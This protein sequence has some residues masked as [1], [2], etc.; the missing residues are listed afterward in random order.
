MNVMRRPI[1]TA[2]LLLLALVPAAAAA[3]RESGE[4]NHETLRNGP[5]KEGA[6]CV[7]AGSVRADK[8]AGMTRDQGDA[9]LKELRQIRQ[10]LEKQQAQLARLLA[11]PPSAPPPPERVQMNVGSGWNALGRADAPVTVVE[12]A[13][14][15]CPFCKRFHSGTFAELKK[16]YIDTG[17]VRWVSRDLPIEIHAHALRAA[18]AARCAGDQGK[19]WEMRD[20][21]LS[22]GS[23]PNDEVIE[24][25]AERLSLD[26]KVFQSCLDS[27][28]HGGEVQKDAMEAATLH[29][30]GT[31][32]F[33][34]ARAA[35]DKLDGVRILGAQALPVFQSAIEPL[36]KNSADRR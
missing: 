22:D 6:K 26:L 4:T 35:R 21:L 15:E 11:S 34:V 18:E 27:E 29:I 13:D 9:V 8:T 19:Y 20:A 2:L 1:E 32:T 23:P 28:K 16:K 10:L 33:V 36:L 30:D 31:P 25:S 3:A 17:K 5:T 24:H 7:R 12:F 14:Y